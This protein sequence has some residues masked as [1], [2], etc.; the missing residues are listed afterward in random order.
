[1]NGGV[2]SGIALDNTSRIF[3]MQDGATNRE[4]TTGNKS[5]S[6]SANKVAPSR[7]AIIC[8][9]VKVKHAPNSPGENNEKRISEGAAS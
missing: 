1:M 6:K 7:N 9:Y 4:Y 5:V 2:L 3:G 8:G